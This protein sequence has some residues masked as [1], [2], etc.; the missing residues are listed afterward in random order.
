MEDPCHIAVKII[1]ECHAEKCPV[2]NGFTTVNYGRQTCA[3][4]KGKGFVIVPNQIED[5][6]KNNDPIGL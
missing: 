2:C 4:C 5:R 3:A 6:R 1:P